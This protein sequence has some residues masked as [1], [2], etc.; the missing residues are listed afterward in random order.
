MLKKSLRILNNMVAIAKEECKTAK[1]Q[2]QIDIIPVSNQVSEEEYN[3][4]LQ[5]VLCIEY[6][7]VTEP[8]IITEVLSTNQDNASIVLAKMIDELLDIV[9]GRYDQDVI[10]IEEMSWI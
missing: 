2:W 10:H 8:E 9:D 6:D 3:C 1:I 5:A 7:W 4:Y